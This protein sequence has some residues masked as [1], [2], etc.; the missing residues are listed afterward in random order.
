[1]S[2]TKMSLIPRSVLFSDPD[3]SSPRLSPNGKMLSFLAPLENTMQVW[4]APVENIDQAKCISASLQPIVKQLWDPLSETLLY[5]H[6]DNGDENWQLWG[7]RI[8]TGETLCYTEPGCTSKII[9]MSLKNPN[10]ILVGINKRDRHYLDAHEIDLTTAQ[11][12]CVYENNHYWDLFADNDL[13]IRLG[14]AIKENQGH[15]VDLAHNI[16]QT[17]VTIHQ[18]D[19]FENYYYPQLRLVFAENNNKFFFTQSIDDTSSLVEYDIRTHA[20]KTLGHHEK[21]DIYD[22]VRHPQTREPIAFASYYDRKKWQALDE[23]TQQDFEYLEKLHHGDISILSQTADNCFWTVA[24]TQDDGPTKFYMYHK[25]QQKA[26]FLFDS[27]TNF[28]KYTFSK[29]QTPLIPVQDGLTCVSYLSRPLEANTPL[30]LVLMIH[31]GPNY[32]DFWGFNPI[33]QWL[34]NRGYAVLSINYRCSSG[35]G[36]KHTLAGYGEWAGKI[37]EDILAATHW[38]IAQ[39]ITTADKIAIMG[40]SFGGYSTLVGLTFTPEVFCCGVDIVGPSNLETML[41]Y[42]PPYW[43]PMLPLIHNMVGVDLTQPEAKNYLAQRSPLHFAHQIQKPLLIGH[44]ANDVRVMQ[45]ESDQMV[46]EMQKNGIPVTY[47]IFPDEGHQF[48]HPGNRNA[49]YG[50]AEAFLAKHLH[51]Q[52][53]PQDNTTHTSMQIKVDDFGLSTA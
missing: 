34:A 17:L 48:L 18:H 20:I 35:F 19:I 37:H 39:K 52:V 15:Y 40:R 28:K 5:L 41:K 49:F 14:L 44:G 38:A 42:F 33:H 29:M 47:A 13:Q 10:K 6:D 1:M 46:Q 16:N 45:S 3:K 11:S 12:T 9:K 27:H 32:R 2:S 51:G 4:L 43:K 24:Y 53:E 21:A 23:D 31:G 50:L 30:P 7:Y 22:I 25:A 36:I 8:S 26:K